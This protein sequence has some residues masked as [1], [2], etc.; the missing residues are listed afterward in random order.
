MKLLITIMKTKLIAVLLIVFLASCSK[1]ET[2]PAPI[3]VNGTWYDEPIKSEAVISETF[4]TNDSTYILKS[5]TSTYTKRERFYLLPLNR[6]VI[7]NT[8]YNYSFNE[9]VLKYGITVMYR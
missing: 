6:M 3:S 4:N 5:L 7:G 2:K 8:T 1:E 9:S